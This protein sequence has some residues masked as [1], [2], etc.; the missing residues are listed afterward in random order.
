MEVKNK[1]G[2]LRIVEAVVAILIVAVAL[3]FIRTTNIVEKTNSDSIYEI[4][5]NILD[6]VS[7][8]DSLRSDVLDGNS[9]NVNKLVE[10]ILSD[11]WAYS[12]RICELDSACGNSQTITD[13]EVY[14]SEMIIV[15]DETQYSPKKLKIF[16]WENE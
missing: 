10:Q 5:R 2:W 9:Q 3:L 16:V 15:A 13:R 12:I 1:K 11:N 7:K 8:N 6:I 14:S 4:E